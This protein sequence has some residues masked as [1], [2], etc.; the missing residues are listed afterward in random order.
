MPYCAHKF[1]YYFG[2]FVVQCNT[3]KDVAI[4]LHPCKFICHLSDI[5]MSFPVNLN[6][7]V[8]CLEDTLQT[9]ISFQMLRILLYSIGENFVVCLIHKGRQM[10]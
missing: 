7:S 9:T 3:Q 5:A 2:F 8:F 1:C 10:F 4:L 6:G